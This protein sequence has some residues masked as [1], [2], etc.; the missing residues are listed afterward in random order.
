M[1]ALHVVVRPS[2][3]GTPPAPLSALT[4]LIDVVVHGVNLTARVGQGPAMDFLIDLSLGLS[5]VVKGARNRVSVPLHTEGEAWELG[6]EGN[7]D[8]VLLSL[9]RVSPDLTV[10]AS[11]QVVPLRELRQA[12]LVALGS[13]LE[14]RDSTATSVVLGLRAALRDLEGLGATPV[15][16]STPRETVQLSAADD[17]LRIDVEATLRKTAVL[18][19]APSRLERADVHALLFRGTLTLRHGPNRVEIAGGQTFLELERLL[20]LVEEAVISRSTGR[21]TF[22]RTKLEQARASLRRGPG[23]APVELRV[24]PL[25]KKPFVSEF[26]TETFTRVVAGAALELVDA[27]CERDPEQLNN[28]RVTRMR[29]LATDLCAQLEPAADDESVTNPQPD[30][31]RRFVPRLKRTKGAWDHGAK[32]RFQ[33]RWVASVPRIDLRG[34]F[35]C[36]DRLIVG[37]FEQTAC[38]E[39]RTGEVVWQKQWAPAAQV[40]TPSG[41]VRIEPDGRLSCHHLDDGEQRFSLRVKPK[42]YGAAT[43]AV[44]YGP[45]LPKLLALTEGDRQVTGIDLVTGEVRWRY[46]AKRAAPYRVRR[47]G[48]LLVIGGGDPLLVAIDGVSGDVVWS[49]KSVLPWSGDIALAH[50][51]ASTLSGVP[52]GRWLLHRLNPFSGE[53]HW[54]VELDDRPLGR[55][56]LLTPSAIVVP[57]IDGTKTGATAYDRETG[58]K[59]WEQ[60]PGLVDGAS[61]WLAVDNDVLVN[62]ARGILMSLDAATGSV[63]FSHVFSS[64]S[65]ADQPRRL[66]P[67]LRSG[68][69][70][71]PQQS[72]HVVRPGSGEILGS[73]PSDL[74]PD[75]VRV[76]ERCDVYVAEESGHM[77]AFS[78]AAKLSLV[79]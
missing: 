49:L 68:A 40:V 22:R 6:L 7:G 9:F 62:S 50:D 52:G 16:G 32:M 33:P 59:L 10:A 54:C 46:T 44:L 3:G 70:F 64:A 35:L 63:R 77:A 29:T 31:Y 43:G 26:S 51:T 12:L 58:K 25:G 38:L 71:V 5:A 78:A 18:D 53:Q 39:R 19:R 42:A 73:L 27:L 55:T 45:S 75:L 57:T 4:G 8:E 23:D 37:G 34:T 17:H 47:A 41:L 60:A 74:V 24:E 56:P 15:A 13:A 36:G 65:E 28:L 2:L 66:E 76:D 69:L 67:I 21:P 1:S 48:R 79:K 20:S 14:V 11:D 72:V 30:S 61:A